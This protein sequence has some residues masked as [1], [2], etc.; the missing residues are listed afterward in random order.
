FR[1]NK[2]QRAMGR[3]VDTDYDKCVGCHI[4][5]EVCPSAYIKMGLI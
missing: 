2:D 1:V 3:Y 5:A 4:C